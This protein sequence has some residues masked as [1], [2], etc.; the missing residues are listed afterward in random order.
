MEEAIRITL[1]V[2]AT[3]DECHTR[4]LVHGSPHQNNVMLQRNLEPVLIDF[5]RVL[6]VGGTDKATH[7]RCSRSWTTAVQ[8]A[9]AKR[10]RP[11]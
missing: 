3:F 5:G 10:F 8:D 6:P 9:H 1:G 4:G 7:P 11:A 2:L